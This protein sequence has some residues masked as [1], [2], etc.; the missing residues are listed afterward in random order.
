MRES[1]EATLEEKKRFFKSAN[2]NFGSSALCLS[3]GA[4]FGYYHTGVCLA[5]LNAGLLPRVVT[6]TSAGALIAA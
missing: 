6:G 5:F 1:T 3:G 2:K 4:S